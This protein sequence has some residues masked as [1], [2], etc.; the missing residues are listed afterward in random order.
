[1]NDI[2]EKHYTYQN[3]SST[4]ESQH[5]RTNQDRAKNE[6]SINKNI[7]DRIVRIGE[8]DI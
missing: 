1:M 2:V 5:T 6:T 3:S 8:T 4:A 7:Y